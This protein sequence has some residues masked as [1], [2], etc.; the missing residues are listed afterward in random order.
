MY[1]IHNNASLGNINSMLNTN[2]ID[3]FNIDLSDDI[4]LENT[5]LDE[6]NIN[7][8]YETKLNTFKKKLN[9]N[10]ILNKNIKYNNKNDYIS[11]LSTVRGK[12]KRGH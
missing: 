9:N 2:I 3:C 7:I 1:I 5:I 6:D 10:N 12:Y 11:K 4:I 8:I